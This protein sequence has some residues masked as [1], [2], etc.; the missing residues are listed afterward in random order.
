MSV[1][2]RKPGASDI[3][4]AVTAERFCLEGEPNRF[5]V[6]P[7]L[8][9]ATASSRLSVAARFC[10]EN[11]GVAKVGSDMVE[12]DVGAVAIA[13][14]RE[15]ESLSNLPPSLRPRIWSDP[16][17]GDLLGARVADVAVPKRL[18]A[19]DVPLGAKVEA[20]VPK[21]DSPGVAAAVGANLI[22]VVVGFQV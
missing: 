12:D 6:L 20:P 18:E 4:E 3:P 13:T 8:A 19:D 2:F 22:G 10:R 15:S 5:G 17:K 21:S 16:T 7:D 9:S 1:L 11:D 14:E